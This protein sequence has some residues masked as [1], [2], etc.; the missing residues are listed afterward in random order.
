MS[1]VPPVTL[2]GAPSAAV[3]LPTASGLPTSA[4]MGVC[5]AALKYV[6]GFPLPFITDGRT[7]NTYRYSSGLVTSA[8]PWTF[9]F[10]P[11]ATTLTNGA[12]V[13]Y[14]PNAKLI[15]LVAVIT[16]QVDIGLGACL[17]T[18]PVFAIVSNS[19][20]V[21]QVDGAAALLSNVQAS[22]ITGTLVM[23][24]TIPVPITAGNAAAFPPA[25][26]GFQIVVNDA[27]AAS[28]GQLCQLY[29]NGWDLT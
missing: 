22:P 27:D 23:T 29:V 4:G 11:G 16:Y 28:F 5:V 6:A 25:A 20:T 2:V 13:G 19:Q 24:V 17:N 15:Q 9:Q 21:G 14:P 7:Q 18:R 3:A 8:G 26:R 12:T 1:N 10:T